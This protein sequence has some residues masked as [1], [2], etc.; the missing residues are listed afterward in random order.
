MF[1]IFHWSVIRYMYLDIVMFFIIM[2]YLLLLAIVF[3]LM[4]LCLML[5]LSSFLGLLLLG[6]MNKFFVE[7]GCCGQYSIPEFCFPFEHSWIFVL[8]GSS[9]AR[10]QTSNLKRCDSSKDSTMPSQ[11]VLF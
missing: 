11:F 7:I 6:I 3:V 9:L 10:T 8:V 5:Q 2:K 1:H 4:T